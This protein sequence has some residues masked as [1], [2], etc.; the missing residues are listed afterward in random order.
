MKLYLLFFFC[1]V[2]S[3]LLGQ[4][5]FTFYFDADEDE[6]LVESVNAFQKWIIKQNNI[7]VHELKAFC[8][9]TKS[10]VYNKQLAERRNQ[11]IQQILIDNQ[12]SF[13]PN[14]TLKSFGENFNA[15]ADLA[16]NRK[17]EVSF[18]T[19]KEP[20][21]EEENPNIFGKNAQ[22][23]KN[24]EFLQNL[25]YVHKPM[26]LNDFY[27]QFENAKDGDRIQIFDIHF[28]L[29]S[30]EMILSSEPY[31][32]KIVQYLNLHPEISIKI[33]GHMCC[34]LMGNASLSEKRAKKIFRYLIMQGIPKNRMK[35]EG[36]GVQYPIFTIPE[37]N[38]EERLKNRRV[39][40]VV[41]KKNG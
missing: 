9:S 28:Y 11:S 19:Q 33:E 20:I 22:T 40:I 23:K 12:V 35:Y 1:L 31:L 32:N 2:Q 25:K 17:V 38:D 10:I 27:E 6:P 8:D 16:L 24:N 30:P 4:E 7:S 29:D 3:C 26:N 37:K 34:N 39:E 5:K 21:I 13:E 15:E 36:L 14:Y 18:T 41:T